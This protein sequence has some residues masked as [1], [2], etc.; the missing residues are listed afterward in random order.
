[1]KKILGGLGALATV[2]LLS[3]PGFGFLVEKGLRQQIEA[4]P[5]QYGMTIEL[6][7]FKRRWF[8]S[9]AKLYWKWYIPAHLT[10]NQLGQTVTVSPQ[11]FEKEF[12]IKI[13]HGPLIIHDKKPF[14]GVGF[15]ET[16]LNWP[17]LNDGPKKED[18]DTKSI[19]PEIKL[20]MAF[21][22][23]L[24]NHWT[25]QV[26]AFD[27]IGKNNG[28]EIKWLGLDLKSRIDRNLEHLQG[29]ID[30]AGIAL[31]K[32]GMTFDVNDLNTNYRL[33]RDNSGVYTGN[34]DIDLKQMGAKGIPSHEWQLSNFM[35]KAS[36]SVNL[37][38]FS[39]NA[40][41]RLKSLDLNGIKQGPFDVDLQIRKI[42][43]KTLAKIHQVLQQN[44]NASP[45]FRSRGFMA[46]LSSIPELL[47]YGLEVELKKLNLNLAKGQMSMNMN[48]SLPAEVS[49]AATWNFQ[50]LQSLE[51]DL[52]IT[53]SQSL[54]KDWILDMLKHQLATADLALD[55]EQTAAQDIDAIASKRTDDKIAA[56]ANQGVLQ[57]QAQDYL[58]HIKLHQGQW[59]VNDLPFD[60][61]WLMF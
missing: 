45:S 54:F 53:V 57:Q 37:E 48:L 29:K 46:V 10:Q 44:Q 23:L 24:Q 50:R 49:N 61:T 18:F 51:G 11:H 4:A 52:N 28:D 8:S 32:F 43:A 16:T 30:F 14:I 27:L 13:F 36:S 41:A 7:D 33:N 59:T 56:L 1:M 19:F 38:H 2:G 3:Y 5:K 60:P 31:H 26:P 9:D 17:L 40:V 42:N 39:T 21:N 20:S 35:L 15:A 22:F 55:D 25:T 34:V 6:K 58:M 12:N 47:K